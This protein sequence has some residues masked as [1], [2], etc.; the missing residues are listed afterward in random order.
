MLVAVVAAVAAAVVLA[1]GFDTTTTTSVPIGVPR[2]ADLLTVTG[3][4]VSR[5]VPPGYIGLS[6]EYTAV[7][8]YAG[9]DPSAINPVFATLLDE[10]TPGGHPVLRIGGD[11]SDWGWFAV[12]GMRKPPG[13]QYTLHRRWVSVTRALAERTGAKLILG[14]N[15]EAGSHRLMAEQVHRFSGVGSALQAFEIGN[16]PEVFGALGWYRSHHHPVYARRRGY[17][18]H[19]YTRELARYTGLV[20]A[21]IPLA[22]PSTGGMR[23]WAQTGNYLREHPRVRVVTYH[24]YPLHECLVDPKG[25]AA[26]TVPH[27]LGPSASTGLAALIAPYVPVAHAHGAVV[28]IDEL[29]SV[30]CGGGPGV[31]DRFASALWAIDTLFALAREGVDGVNF[32]T[33]TRAYYRPFFFHH[34]AGRWSATIAPMYY[35]LLAFN[36]AAPAGSKLLQTSV[37]ASSTLRVWATRGRDGHVRVMLINTSP[38]HARTIAIKLPTSAHTATLQRLRAPGLGSAEGV[39]LGGQRFTRPTTTGQLTG[40]RVVSTPQQVEPGVYLLGMPPGSAAVL[41][42]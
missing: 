5:P 25:P 19:D 27:L 12:P 41:T 13:I 28:R 2:G 3:T 40:P 16:E 11:T 37:P 22:G 17:D 26:S 6:L 30:S 21:S 8:H 31:S 42:R 7:E 18:Y 34:T 35:G 23:F 10:L 1:L 29:N 4:P 36:L 24:L 9:G 32:H 38:S 33:F 15:L 14:L 20:P 39:T